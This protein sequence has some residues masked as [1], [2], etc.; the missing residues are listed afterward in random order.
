[1]IECRYLYGPIEGGKTCH[2]GE[3]CSLR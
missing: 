1:V 3:Y 2:M